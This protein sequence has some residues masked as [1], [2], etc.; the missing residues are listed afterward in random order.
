MDDPL[1]TVDAHVGRYLFTNCIKGALAKK[2]RL[3]VTHHLHYLPQVDYI[4][5]MEDG[6]IAEQ[7][8]YEE[9]IKNRKNFSKLIAKYGGAESDSKI[10]E[11]EESILDIKENKKDQTVVLSKGLMSIEEQ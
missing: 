1:S 7:G 11:D 5:C 2:T 4:I 10:K 9:L 3:L 6:E 8:T